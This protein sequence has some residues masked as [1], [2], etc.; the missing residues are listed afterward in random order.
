MN[1]SQI[2]AFDSSL[3]AIAPS[4]F[5]PDEFF[6]GDNDGVIC[7]YNKEKQEVF[8]R[9]RK[10]V[11]QECL[12]VSSKFIVV[13][14]QWGLV[15]IYD[16]EKKTTIECKTGCTPKC[17]RISSDETMF[18]IGGKYGCIL[19]DIVTGQE[20]MRYPEEN[21]H[22]VA[23]NMTNTGV[24]SEGFLSEI[25][26][27]DVQ[28]G[29]TIMRSDRF[30]HHIES[31]FVS[32]N[33]IAIE[34]GFSTSV[35]ILDPLTLNLVRSI[36]C[37]RGRDKSVVFSPDGAYFLSLTQRRELIV[38]DST[39]GDKIMNL[40]NITS[41]INSM[42]FSL[43]GKSFALVSSKGILA[44]YKNLPLFLFMKKNGWN[45][46][47]LKTVQSF[48]HALIPAFNPL[49]AFNDSD[50]DNYFLMRILINFQ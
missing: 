30:Q 9:K 19:Y 33:F 50:Y 20:R 28:T 1:P 17:L 7:R 12:D 46:N 16:I 45:Q 49:A 31:I 32:D 39:T 43:D 24:F 47:H 14:Y 2:V 18:V 34:S 37:Q 41:N 36:K 40:V 48:F 21:T 13:S 15:L 8:G 35:L 11:Q 3:R 25:E 26:L 27:W 5:S 22:I 4:R 29:Q 10:I 6:I 23:F 42:C 38:W 44:I